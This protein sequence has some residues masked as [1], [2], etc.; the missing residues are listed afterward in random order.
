M[1]YFTTLGKYYDMQFPES[2]YEKEAKFIEYVIRK[3]HPGDPCDILDLMCG[4]GRHAVYLARAGFTVTG[5]DNSPQMLEI[6][7]QR[8]KKEQLEIIFELKDAITME[9]SNKYDVVYCWFNSFHYLYSNDD[10]VTVLRNIY[11][12]LKKDG[13]FVVDIRNGSW[14]LQHKPESP[15]SGIIEEGNTKL[16]ITLSNISYHSRDQT[17][18]MHYDFF[19]QEEGELHIEHEDHKYRLFHPLEFQYFL[20]SNKFEILDI[21]GSNFDINEKFN[22]DSS[23]MVFV[24][25]KKEGVF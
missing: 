1:K 8:G 5:I 19:I 12:A 13:L 24:A 6:A 25:L 3:H 11:R 14:W 22:A 10:I 7:Q 23:Q 18:S 20:E 21:Y 4:T 17:M 2:K 16:L 9:Y 15:F